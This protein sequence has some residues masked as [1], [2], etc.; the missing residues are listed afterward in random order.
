M[1]T[2][3]PRESATT[4]SL[5]SITARFCPYCPNSTDA[6]RLSSKSSTIRVIGLSCDDVAVP[7]PLF[8]LKLR[9]ASGLRRCEN[10]IMCRLNVAGVVEGSVQAV[11]GHV[12]DMDLRDPA[13]KV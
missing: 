11:C 8:G 4:P 12:V 5:R 2:W 7:D 9:N 13:N 1:V 6:R 10:A 3:L